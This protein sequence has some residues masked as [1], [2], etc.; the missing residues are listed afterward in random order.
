MMY[1]NGQPDK[2][3][4]RTSPSAQGP[5]FLL[6]FSCVEPGTSSVG[7]GRLKAFSVRVDIAFNINLNHWIR[8]CQMGY[9]HLSQ[10]KQHNS[11]TTAVMATKMFA[12]IELQ[13]NVKASKHGMMYLIA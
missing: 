5:V 12:R 4:G 2:Y 8:K 13:D 3:T 7:L 11:P 1:L 10:Q 9:C 6:F